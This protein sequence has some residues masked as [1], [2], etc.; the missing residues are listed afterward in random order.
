MGENEATT[1][2]KEAKD[3]AKEK[4][5]DLFCPSQIKR[6]EYWDG[7]NRVTNI[8]VLNK[9]IAEKKLR[10]EEVWVVYHPADEGGQPIGNSLYVVPWANIVTDGFGHVL[11]SYLEATNWSSAHLSSNRVMKKAY[12]SLKFCILDKDLTARMTAEATF[13]YVGP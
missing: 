12:D 2:E 4:L 1:T 10:A 8:Q 13:K 7:N 3:V 11:T 6:L 5:D 9:K